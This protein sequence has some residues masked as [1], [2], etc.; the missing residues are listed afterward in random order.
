MMM[1]CII[2]IIIIPISSSSSSGSTY[3]SEADDSAVNLQVEEPHDRWYNHHH[4]PHHRNHRNHHHHHHHRNHHHLHD[5]LIDQVTGHQFKQLSK[6][7][8]G[9]WW[10][11]QVEKHNNKNNDWNKTYDYNQ[12]RLNC[13]GYSGYENK[14]KYQNL[15]LCN[16]KTKIT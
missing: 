2:I 14:D 3:S 10:K 1:I 7:H 15:F 9:N 5:N 12:N 13:V 8:I 11:S 16:M 6:P 4:H